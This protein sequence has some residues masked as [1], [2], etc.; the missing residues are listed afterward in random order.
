MYGGTIS[1]INT[2][3]MWCR[4]TFR[5]EEWVRCHVIAT[6]PFNLVKDKGSIFF[7]YSPDRNS[8]CTR[9]I[10]ENFLQCV[11]TCNSSDD[12]DS[13]SKIGDKIRA[14]IMVVVEG[15]DFGVVDNNSDDGGNG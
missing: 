5:K 11:R 10:I 4:F 2:K 9:T 8:K 1:C 7:N 13:S 14:L 15:G 3:K 6:I 12:A